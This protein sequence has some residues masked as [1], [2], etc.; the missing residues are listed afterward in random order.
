MLDAID[1]RAS[2]TSVVI[3][4]MVNSGYQ[5]NATRDPAVSDTQLDPIAEEWRLVP[6]FDDVEASSTGQVR[7]RL[8]G[9]AVLLRPYPCGTGYVAVTLKGRSVYVHS[10]VAAAFLGP[11]PPGHVVVHLDDNSVSNVASALAYATRGEAQRR[12]YARGTR[13]P[14]YGQGRSRRSIGLTEEQVREIRDNPLIRPSR[15]ARMFGVSCNCISAVRSRKT[16][17]HLL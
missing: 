9:R 2:Y 16:W 12:A 13:Q 17:R 11:R 1:R 6:G 5:K 3:G 4:E 7:A 15:F 10:L 14:T 8:V